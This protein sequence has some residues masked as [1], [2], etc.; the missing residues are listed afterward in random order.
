MLQG[1]TYLINGPL[2][3]FYKHHLSAPNNLRTEFAPFDL[4]LLPDLAFSDEETWIEV[5]G[6]DGSSGVF[7]MP[8]FLLRFMTNRSRADRVNS[9]FLCS[10][11]IGPQGGLPPDDATASNPDLT[12]RTG[13][14]YCHARLEPMAAYWGRWAQNGSSYLDPD[15]FPAFEEFCMTCAVDDITCNETC[16]RFYITEGVGDA[17]LE[18]LGW[19]DS[20][21]VLQER[22]Y[23][24]VELGPHR[25]IQQGL[26]DGSLSTCAVKTVV[27]RLM[28]RPLDEDEHDHLKQSLISD[29]CDSQYRYRELVRAVVLSDAYRR[30]P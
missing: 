16:D 7:T 24:H 1:D 10:E 11:F 3:H 21:Q 5:P 27:Q 25:L 2:V 22:Y 9:A 8:G 17:E 15:Q 6:V 13:C 28:R 19:F 18:W 4:S 20:Y 14:D 30:L 12:Q 26:E 23:D 29:I